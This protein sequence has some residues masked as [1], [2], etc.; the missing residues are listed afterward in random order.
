MLYNYDMSKNRIGIILLLLLLTV[1]FATVT[2]NLII[3][4][5]ANISATPDDF[6]VIFI[7]ATSEEGGTATISNDKKMITYSTKELKNIGDKAELDYTIKNNSSQYDAEIDMSISFDNTYASYF[8]ITYET[9]DDTNTV[10]IDA[11]EE[12][13]GKIIIELIKY[14]IDDMQISMDITFDSNAV[15]RTSIAHDDYTV[16]FNGNGNTSGS[17]DEQTINYDYSTPLRKN[18]FVKDG[19]SFI[20]WTSNPTTKTDYY[21]DEQE[22]TRLTDENTV[23][24]LYAIWMK[25]DYSY[26]GNYQEVI[27]PVDGVYQIELWGAQGG[28]ASG[29]S[30]G[31]GGY[32]KGDISLNK[33]DKLYIYVGGAGQAI[34]KGSGGA[35]WNGGGQGINVHDSNNRSSGGGGATDI[36]LSSGAWNDTTGLRSRIMVAAG[37]GGASNYGNGGAGGGLIGIRDVARNG[38]SQ[39]NGGGG[40]QTSGGTVT[41]GGYGATNGSFGAGSIGSSIGGGGGGGYYGGAGGV[42]SSPQDGPG[43]G[44]SSFISGHNGCNAI[45]SSGTHTGQSVHYSGLKFTN[46]VMIDGQGYNWTTERG[47]YVG[48]V[49]PNGSTAAGHSGNGY[50][51]IKFL[52]PIH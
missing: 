13:S 20:G 11:K 24:E 50:A 25:N 34:G 40:T 37:A 52:N 12:K 29:Y 19:Y 6:S 49:Q 2:A 16:R 27:I 17:M 15:G 14:A 33:N 38:Y 46:T 39:Y 43:G 44:G 10:L 36:R 3:N 30:I 42:R 5:N 1:G 28:S 9:F 21:Y 45:T 51:R 32:T 23:I 47:S 7:S 26:T 22:V 18:L 48:Q 35:G 8:R 41:N 4:N 31:L